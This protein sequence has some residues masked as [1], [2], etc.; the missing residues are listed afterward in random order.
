MTV[1]KS[2][3]HPLTEAQ[4]GLWYAQALD[5][6]N[7]ILNAGQYLELT[8]PLDRAALLE[9]VARTA[10]ETPALRLRF[11]D[12][13][14]GPVQWF[15]P[16]PLAADVVDL[17]GHDD[18]L[19]AA[20]SL[21]AEDAGRALD[22]ARDPV[23][24]FM[25]FILGQGQHLLYER[26]HHLALDGYGFVLVTNRIADHYD[27][28]TTAAPAPASFGDFASVLA[29]DAAWRTAPQRDAARDWWHARLAGL[30]EARGPAAGRAVSAH[31]FRRES[32]WL[33]PDLLARL[34]AFATEH[35]IGWP[36][37]LTGLASAYLARWTGG[38]IVVGLP[39]MARMGRPIA[40]IPCMAMNVLPQRVSPQED[41]PTSDWLSDLAS[42]MREARR[43]GLYRS[44]YLRRELGLIGGTRRL[45]GPLIN[46]QPFDRPPRFAGLQ[47]ALHILGAGAVDDLTLTFRGDPAAGLLFEVDANPDLYTAEDVR[48]HSARLPAFLSAAL[49]LP[50]LALV[51]TAAPAEIAATEAL[52]AG[53][54]HPVPDTTLTEL[55]AA[56]IAATP[57]APAI[58]AGETVLSYRDL[59]QRSAAL[60]AQ[61][62]RVGAGPDRIVAVALDRSVELPVALLAILRTG[63]AYLPLDPDHPKERLAGIM[64]QAKPAALLTSPALLDRIPVN[65]P[66][67]LTDDW[68][69]DGCGDLPASSP[70]DLAYVIFTSGSTGAPKGV[71]VEHRAIVNRLLWMA[72]EYGISPQDRVL[73]KTPASFDVSVWEFF[74]PLMTGAE[75]VMAPPGAHRDPALLGAVIRR[76]RITTLHFV[77]S[78]LSAFLAAP[79]SAGLSLTRVFCSGEELGADLRDRFHR[80]I[81]AELHNLYG[82]TEAAVDVSYWPAGA[83][84][85][86]DPVPIG[87]PVWNTRLAVLDSRMRPVP[88]GLAGDLYL[89]G[90]QLA[91][92]YLDRDDLTRDRFIADPAD[93]GGRLYATGDLARLRPDGAVVFLGRSDHQVKIRGLRIELGEIEAA[94]MATGLAREAV[95]IAREDH[96]GEKRLTAYLVPTPQHVP[97]LLAKRLAGRLPGYMLP[98]AEVLLD[99]MPVTVNGKLDR[100]ALP[101]PDFSVT[102]RDAETG[103]ERLLAGLYAEILHL[104]EPAGAETDFFAAGGDSLS[105]VNLSL[106]IAEATGHET[107]LGVIFENPVLSALAAALERGAVS[108]GLG[109]LMLLADGDEDAPPLVLI[110]PAG[111]LAWGYRHLARLIAPARRVY[112]IQH[113]GLDLSCAMPGSLDA[114]AHDYATLLRR[115]FG[116]GR[117]HLA[118]WSVGGIIAQAMAAMIEADGDSVGAVVLLDSYPAD[119]WRDAPAPDPVQA[120]RAL[121]AIAGLD[122]DAHQEL[123]SRDKVAAFLRGSET[124]LGALP[125]AVMD[126]VIRVVTD[127]NRLVRGHHHRV[128]RGDLVHIAAALDHHGTSLHAGM[129]DAYAQGVERHGIAQLH[130]GMTSA[131]ASADIAPI[132]IA[133]MAA[134][135]EDT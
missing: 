81:T 116:S 65:L 16:A 70:E 38:E 121:L 95:V 17:T 58:R 42:Q 122:P 125:E 131:A 53:A 99:A 73:Q 8:G 41:R 127:T 48:G 6:A 19:A 51:P 36:D 86:S 3:L 9:A 110:H 128:L 50:R 33:P 66:V 21:M 72:A 118:G 79:A 30:P 43:H 82:P 111:G 85:T 20:R 90:R 89:G 135:E 88:P 123:D 78:M 12:G 64:A 129:W 63:A 74:L 93:P 133:A 67:L 7:P 115:T 49:D 15:D 76:H 5:R 52:T 11:G 87:W 60:A 23:A 14:N 104:P 113:P 106:R 75:L 61:L 117:V 40:R 105:A 102:G 119:A 100:K 96:A 91:R 18:P 109:P 94:I 25:L 103:L 26:V 107:G 77:P 39:F 69:T 101:V 84:D 27:A 31:D 37:V 57:D 47:T 24:V 83:A 35:R 13:A 54:R 112:G 134:R 55:I 80:R 68:A 130:S 124:A 32:C 29:E 2:H 1:E 46:I 126:G 62:R 98:A 56:Q 132:L 22:L 45:Y 71:A 28:L 4:E 59:D 114:L 10:A 92:G 120:L 44:E 97:G 108:D 34:A